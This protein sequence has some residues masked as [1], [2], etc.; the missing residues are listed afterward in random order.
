MVGQKLEEGAD[1]PDYNLRK[2]VGAILYIAVTGR[3]DV[4]YAVS[5]LARHVAKPTTACR[6]AAKR[7][8][9][10]LNATRDWGPCYTR[11]NERRFLDNYRAT[12]EAGG[13]TIDQQDILAFTDASFADSVELKST[14][15]A[16]V[17]YCSVAIA[18]RS[19]KQSLR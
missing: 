4:S 19:A 7:L 15:G 9:K 12:L 2:V 13:Y 11:D 3:P 18:W 17:Y 5:K 8:L 6:T 1:C 10:Y 14:S 16:V